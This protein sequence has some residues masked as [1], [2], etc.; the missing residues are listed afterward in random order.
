MTVTGTGCEQVC[1]DSCPEPVTVSITGE[2][3]ASRYRPGGSRNENFPERRHLDQDRRAP[4]LA[5][6]HRAGNRPASGLLA[7]RAQRAARQEQQAGDLTRRAGWLAGHVTGAGA[8]PRWP[9]RTR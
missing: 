2:R 4:S 5:K 6:D 1:C 9:P 3:R 8:R 7:A